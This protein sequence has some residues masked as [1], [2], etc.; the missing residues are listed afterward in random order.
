M[1]RGTPH[2]DTRGYGVVITVITPQVALIHRPKVHH[3]R[4]WKQRNID[5]M[6]WVMVAD[7][8]VRYLLGSDPLFGQRGDDHGAIG[9]H[10]RIDYHADLLSPNEDDRSGDVPCAIH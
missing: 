1:A 2:R 3:F 5:R 10:T 9:H 4:V 6:V 8:D 7:K